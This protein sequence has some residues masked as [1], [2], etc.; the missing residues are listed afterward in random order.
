MPRVNCTTEK[1]NEV[2]NSQELGIQGELS[3]VSSSFFVINLFATQT[4]VKVWNESKHVGHYHMHP[5]EYQAELA[6]FLDHLGFLP[7]PEL[8][9]SF[10]HDK[11]PTEVYKVHHRRESK[12]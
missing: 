10:H 5:K 9:A 4:Y 8:V 11:L 2:Q 12:V 3:L 1:G 7:R 6:A